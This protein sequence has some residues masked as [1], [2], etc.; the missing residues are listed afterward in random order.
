M[1]SSKE[2]GDAFK[3]RCCNALQRELYREFEPEARINMGDHFYKIFDDRMRERDI[4][5]ECKAMTYTSGPV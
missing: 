4:V 5:V 1:M 3:L 2:R